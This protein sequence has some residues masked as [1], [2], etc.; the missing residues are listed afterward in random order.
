MDQNL[1]HRIRERAYEIWATNGCREGEAER[2][3]LAAEQ[4]ILS[5]SAVEI[6]S[7]PPVAKKASRASARGS[8]KKGPRVGN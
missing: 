3:W 6:G 8:L 4:E 1:T 5:I 7:T 2:H